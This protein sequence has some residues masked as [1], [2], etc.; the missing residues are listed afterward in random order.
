MGKGGGSQTTTQNTVAEP[1]S[2]V[3][4]QLIRAAEDAE[5]LYNAGGM[6]A[7]PF[8]GSRLANRSPE[9]LAALG[10]MTNTALTSGLNQ[11]VTNTY[12]DMLNPNPYRDL[13]A[14]SSE[15]LAAALPGVRSMYA[16]SGMMNSSAAQEGITRAATQAVAPIHFDAYQ[17]DQNRRA[18][19][20]GM[21][22]TM[23][24]LQYADDQMLAQIGGVQDQRAQAELDDTISRHYEDENRAYDEL[25]RYSGLMM[26]YGGL[27][28]TT[29]GTTT[30]QNSPGALG[31]AGAGLSLLPLLFSDRRLKR[32]IRRIGATPKGVPVYRFKYL[33]SDQE[34]IGVMSDEVPPHLVVQIGG[35]DA[36]NY[37][38]LE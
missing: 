35:F 1:W 38:G 9:T 31:I 14:V 32:D 19:L 26:G 25:A 10:G 3:Q 33:W 21:A 27:G 20:L 6:V 23:N 18:S 15:A 7:Q 8:A 13:D 5:A 22:P 36:V 2:A 34:H 11:N 30:Q 17:Q 28:G 4:P 12:Q 24:N 37:A 16:N 29:S